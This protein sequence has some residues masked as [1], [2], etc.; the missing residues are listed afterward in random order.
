MKPLYRS[1][2]T[3][4]WNHAHSYHASQTQYTIPLVF[5]LFSWNANM[6][7]PHKHYNNIE[8]CDSVNAVSV[9]VSTSL[10]A[11]CISFEYNV[12]ISSAEGWRRSDTLNCWWSFN[13][14]FAVRARLLILDFGE[15]NADRI[16]SLRSYSS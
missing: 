13:G 2:S 12:S 16:Q 6:W 14:D 11:F 9:T 10:F 15:L 7:V 8:C 3:I 5:T 1:Y 4:N